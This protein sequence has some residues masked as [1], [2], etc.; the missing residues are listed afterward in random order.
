MGSRAACWIS[1]LS[2]TLIHPGDGAD[3]EQKARFRFPER[4]LQ[5]RG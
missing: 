5:K 4:E 3:L 2:R 1:E